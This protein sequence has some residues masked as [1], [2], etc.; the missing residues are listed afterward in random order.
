MDGQ[1]AA[2]LIAVVGQHIGGGKGRIFV[3]DEARPKIILGCDC[4]DAHLHQARLGG[5]AVDV[6]G[7]AR[8]AQREIAQRQGRESRGAKGLRWVGQ[9]P[10]HLLVI[11]ALELHQRGIGG[12][13]VGCAAAGLGIVV[14][15]PAAAAQNHR[16]IQVQR[17]GR[18]VQ[19]RLPGGLRH[20]AWVV[21]LGAGEGQAALA[22]GHQQAA[23]Q[24]QCCGEVV[25]RIVHACKR[26]PGVT[27]RV[28]QL[29]AV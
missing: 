27:G 26:G 17:C 2:Q 8:C 28:I 7:E 6:H 13:V 14:A 5:C 10:D 20:P 12:R 19:L 29:N 1:R 22:A 9:Q 23:I 18:G 4:V 16:I 21:D 25:T 24:Q 15:A 3:G 11:Q